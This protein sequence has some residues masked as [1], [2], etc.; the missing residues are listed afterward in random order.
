[1]GTVCIA[2]KETDDMEDLARLVREEHLV[3]YKDEHDLDFPDVVALLTLQHILLFIK[4][5]F[6]IERLWILG[7]VTT[8]WGTTGVLLIGSYDGLTNRSSLAEIADLSVLSVEGVVELG[9][10]LRS[11]IRCVL[12]GLEHTVS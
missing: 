10:L 1:M 5:A 11:N 8:G 9:I 7:A 4:L 3:L 2:F 12:E 6:A